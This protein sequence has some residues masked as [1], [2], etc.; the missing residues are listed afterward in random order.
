MMKTFN[1]R[2]FF[3]I[4]LI[5]SF[6]F[7]SSVSFANTTEESIPHAVSYEIYDENGAL[8]ETG[9]LPSSE[10]EASSRESFPSQTLANGQ[11]MYLKNPATNRPFDVLANKKM[12]LKFALNRTANMRVTF[13]D[14]YYK[15]YLG[16][17]WE[18]LTGGLSI[19]RTT[20]NR[21]SYVQVE[22]RNFSSDPVTVLWATLDF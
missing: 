20:P 12:H 21:Q 18:G 16:N 19:S 14:D 6:L 22:I 9:F 17:P 8:V 5:F 4:S 7:I 1:K 3:I 11:T 2:H 13:W 15:A 10:I